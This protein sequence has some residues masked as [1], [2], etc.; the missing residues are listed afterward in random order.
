MT[1]IDLHNFPRVSTAGRSWT[2]P[3]WI[4]ASVTIVGLAAVSRLGLIALPFWNDSGLYIALGRSIARGD[5]MYRDFYETK[6]PG[7]GM[8]MSAA[9]RAFGACWPAY[10]AAQFA[11]TL[12]AAAAVARAVAR[13]VAPAAGPPC[14]LYA[15]A[16][17]NFDYTV[18]TGFQ[19][20]TIQAMFE[21]LAAASAIEAIATGDGCSA[22]VAGLAA[23]VAAMA[24]PG[25]AAVAVALILLLGAARRWRSIVWVLAGFSIPVG[26]TFV[27]TFGTGAWAYLPGAIGDIRRY[28]A[29]TPIAWGDAIHVVALVVALGVPFAAIAAARL[30][31]AIGPEAGLSSV[32]PRAKAARL[33][34]G[35]RC[36]LPIALF[37]TAWFLLDLAAAVA[38]R[39]M[40]LYY[41]L[42][43][44]GPAAVLYGMA[45]RRFSPVAVTIGLLPVAVLSLTWDG[46]RPG[47]SSAA[48]RPTSVS[49]YISA[50]TRPG[51]AV[52]ADPVGRVTIE[53]DREPG[54]SAGILFYWVNDDDAPRRYCTRLIAD[55][56]SR[57]TKY[58][59]LAADWD[60][61][62][63]QMADGTILRRCPVR[64]A[65]FI[66]NWDRFRRY[67]HERYDPETVIDGNVIFRRR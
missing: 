51:D 58:I 45:A 32:R 52:Y 25:G 19:L 35:N 15:V 26:A 47:E 10:V 8:L 31:A 40:Y 53:T 67:L 14:F 1:A 41:F 21:C 11:M 17:L 44:T 33:R 28:A 12:V 29:G 9:W 57:R 36:V 56:E 4:V 54:A 23:G 61:P 7:V 5:V 20:E 22:G 24:K 2:R 30:Q 48:L 49:V 59:V 63:P 18:F 38:Q 13:H 62:V 65:R 43:L 16:Y 42:P 66:E 6:L 64:R 27:F 55:L 60:V 34:Y 39:R 37:A 50:H 46:C 3:L